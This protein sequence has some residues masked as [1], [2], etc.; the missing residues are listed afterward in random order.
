MTD[1]RPRPASAIRAGTFLDLGDGL[2]VKWLGSGGARGEVEARLLIIEPSRSKT[3]SAG[4]R[5]RRT[6]DANRHLDT[7]PSYQPGRNT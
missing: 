5:Y 1:T 7:L 2:I 4:T 3:T 6:F